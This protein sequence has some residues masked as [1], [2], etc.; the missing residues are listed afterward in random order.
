MSNMFTSTKVL[1]TNSILPNKN[2]ECWAVG[3]VMIE[4]KQE[5]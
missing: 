1:D 4:A 2:P 5:K 3:Y